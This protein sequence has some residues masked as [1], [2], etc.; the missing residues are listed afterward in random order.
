MTTR[1]RRPEARRA[2][3]RS[4][5]RAVARPVRAR[6]RRAAPAAPSPPAAEQA[7]EVH[8]RLAKAIP[9]PRCELDHRDP[10]QLLIATILSAQT[11][12]ARVN[13]V[14]PELFRRWPDAG[15]LASAPPEE[16][17][18]VIR[19]TNFYR[20][21]ARSITRAA[22]KVAG[23]FG[24]AVPRTMEEMLTLPGVARKTA[25][26]VLGTGYGI[27]TGIVVDTH[28]ARVSRRLGLTAS[29]DPPD[30]ESDLCALFP[31]ARWVATG[32]RL[33][34]HG[35]YVCVAR[36]PRCSSCP[37]N[38]ICPSRGEPPAGTWQARAAGERRVVESGGDR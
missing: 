2:A 24:G 27:A 25:N 13:A 28:V 23:G 22:Q 12:D 10:W 8:R 31:R 1:A 21:K 36:A 16:V 3:P 19:S 38:E 30:V 17:E 29:E 37:L 14:T 18:P 15:A 34:L 35:R 20:T 26:V 7:R 33:L 11:T 9:T 6:A 5:A 4:P 32:H